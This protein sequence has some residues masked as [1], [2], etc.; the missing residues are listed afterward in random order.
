MLQTSDLDSSGS[1]MLAFTRTNI[2]T[3][4]P[5]SYAAKETLEMNGVVILERL[6]TPAPDTDPLLF[7]MAVEL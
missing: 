3:S 6:P 5:H 2:E 4:Y 7:S 1:G